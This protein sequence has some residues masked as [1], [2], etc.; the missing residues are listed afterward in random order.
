MAIR[1]HIEI[2]GVRLGIGDKETLAK[3]SIF[4]AD[5]DRVRTVSELE[6]VYLFIDG[7]DR[8]EL[9]QAAGYKRGQID[10]ATPLGWYSSPEIK[11][12]FA[13][14]GAVWSYEQHRHGAP[15]WDSEAWARLDL[16]ILMEVRKMR[17]EQV[18][19]LTS[20][21]VNVEMPA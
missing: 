21:P 9:Y 20:N 11:D 2:N 14:E 1:D 12:R 8:G 3:Y 19:E 13:K 10:F 15:V 16:L 18:N 5:G 6:D 17:A 7:M 4:Y